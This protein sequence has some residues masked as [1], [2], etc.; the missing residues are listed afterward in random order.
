MGGKELDTMAAAA[1]ATKIMSAMGQAMQSRRPMWHSTRPT[2]DGSGKTIWPRLSAK[3]AFILAAQCGAQSEYGSLHEDVKALLMRTRGTRAGIPTPVA[4]ALLRGVKG[5]VAWGSITGTQADMSVML[6]LRLFHK[7]PCVPGRSKSYYKTS[8]AGVELMEYWC[9]T[10]KQFK[11]FYDAF[12]SEKEINRIR[13]WSVTLAMGLE[14]DLI[15]ERTKQADEAMK[16]IEAEQQKI[17]AQYQG[18]NQHYG[19]A[20]ALGLQNIAPGHYT[21]VSPGM[22]SGKQWP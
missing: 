9:S 21:Q 14:I 2:T 13:S 8:A 1:Y 7:I 10:D 16:K 5:K 3:S 12:T 6:M 11:K 18:M 22:F 19:Y 17:N 20:N 15:E 4:M